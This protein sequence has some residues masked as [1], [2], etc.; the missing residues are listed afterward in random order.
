MAGELT[1]VLGLSRKGPRGL[2]GE[3]G[4]AGGGGGGGLTMTTVEKDLGS[5]PVQTGRF[6]I[7]GAGLVVGKPVL[8]VKA[9]GPY[10]GKGTLTDE[11]EMD[12]MTFSGK[13][14]SATLIEVFW[15]S[16]GP[17]VGNVKVDYAVSG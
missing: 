13:V 2:E 15:Q 17:V 6:T 7:S 5:T 12:Q 16:D 10:T 3:Q 4:P 11:A 1:T 14:I 9:N 8:V